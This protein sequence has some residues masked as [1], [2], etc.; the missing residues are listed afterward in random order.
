MTSEPDAPARS[1]WR[2]YLVIALVTL[3]PF[4][5]IGLAVAGMALAAAGDPMAGT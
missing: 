1:H 2:A 4:L 3:S 5:L